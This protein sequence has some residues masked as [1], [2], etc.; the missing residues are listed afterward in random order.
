M[1]SG[2][3]ATEGAEGKRGMKGEKV[4]VTKLAR[5]TLL[6]GFHAS[7]SRRKCKHTDALASAKVN[8]LFCLLY[9]SYLLLH[10]YP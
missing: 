5:E 3:G 8:H 7:F 10:F 2:Y 4:M 9:G 1:A 6:C